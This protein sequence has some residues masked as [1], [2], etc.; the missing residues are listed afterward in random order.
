MLLIITPFKNEELYIND[1]LKAICEG[2]KINNNF[3]LLLI[4]DNSSDK[5]LQIVNDYINKYSFI[6]CINNSEKGKVEAINLAIKYSQ[7]FSHVKLCD[8]DDIL[9]ISFFENI[10]NFFKYDLSIHDL[11]ITKKNL[12]YITTLKINKS[13]LS[14][15]SYAIN[16]GIII[17][18]ACWTFKTELIRDSLIPR[19]ILFEDFWLSFLFKH[20][21]KPIYY[22]ENVSFYLYRQNDNQTFG[23]VLNE[24]RPLNEWRY[25]RLIKCYEEL[26]KLGFNKNYKINTLILYYKL[27]INFELLKYLQLIYLNSKLSLKLIANKLLGKNIPRIKKIFWKLR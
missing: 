7:P 10:N 3:K 2:F 14:K 27:N 11:N 4:N 5:S 16:N 26:I 23:G 12:D 1:Y 15:G 20:K 21:E 13:I 22:F 25:K 24:N 8:A 6:D 18:K 17:P 9:T 19:G